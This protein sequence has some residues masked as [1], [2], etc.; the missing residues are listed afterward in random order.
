MAV[1]EVMRQVLPSKPELA[2]IWMQHITSSKAVFNAFMYGEAIREFYA[3]PSSANS[4]RRALEY[5]ARTV[6]AI[7]KNLSDPQKACSDENIIAVGN[8][9]QHQTLGEDASH[10]SLPRPSQG[11]LESLQFLDLYGGRIEA[12]EVH[13]MAML[14]MIQRRGGIENCTSIYPA[15]FPYCM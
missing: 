8:L 11:P 3:S 7:N 2:D 1:N 6:Q 10:S 15:G 14:T 12:N 13:R 4:K 5:H 9:A